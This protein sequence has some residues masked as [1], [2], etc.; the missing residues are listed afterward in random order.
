MSK[1]SRYGLAVM[2][3]FYTYIISAAL[4]LAAPP[5]P[6]RPVYGPSGNFYTTQRYFGTGGMYLGRART[7]TYPNVYRSYYYNNQ[8]I[9]S[10]Q[11]VGRLPK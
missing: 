11:Q 3:G 4:L 8:G 9:Y 7:Y 2:I 1:V 10:G 5:V 6:V